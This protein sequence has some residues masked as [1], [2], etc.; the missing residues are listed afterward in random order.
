MLRGFFYRCYATLCFE[1]LKQRIRMKYVK[2]LYNSLR[3]KK[4][5]KRKKAIT[6][7]QT[8]RFYFS[9]YFFVVLFS[10]EGI[11][12][13]KVREC[14]FMPSVTILCCCNNSCIA[15]PAKY[16]PPVSVW[17]SEGK[18]GYKPTTIFIIFLFLFSLCLPLL[19]PMRTIFILHFAS[20]PQLQFVS[21]LFFH[22][23]KRGLSTA[24]HT[25]TSKQE[26]AM[27]TKS[28]QMFMISS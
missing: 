6:E 15:L 23:T 26:N 10:S 25:I 21:F 2:R 7:R 3:K 8:I 18:H 12:L 17:E 4:W 16:L 13:S 28:V 9:L 1:H 24:M 5:W 11:K 19:H 27:P 22:R 14:V 20:L